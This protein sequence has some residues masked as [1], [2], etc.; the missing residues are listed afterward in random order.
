MNLQL[1]GLNKC[2]VVPGSQQ[3]KSQTQE[4]RETRDLGVC[5]TERRKPILGGFELRDTQKRAVGS[6]DG[7]SVRV[8]MP[9]ESP[10]KGY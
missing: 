6:E 9:A 3:K 4:E 2:P 8:P 1:T 7:L 10:A 5:E